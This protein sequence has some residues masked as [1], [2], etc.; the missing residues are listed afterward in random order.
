M[1]LLQLRHLVAAELPDLRADSGVVTRIKHDQ[2]DGAALIVSRSIRESQ[3]P[4]NLTRQQGV[5]RN[6]EFDRATLELVCRDTNV[7]AVS[8]AAEYTQGAQPAS[9]ERGLH[10]GSVIPDEE[11]LDDHGVAWRGWVNPPHFPQIV[12]AV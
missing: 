1:D 7:R 3:L 9:R 10:K 12:R 6:A 5:T 8:Q 11:W 2:P 4:E